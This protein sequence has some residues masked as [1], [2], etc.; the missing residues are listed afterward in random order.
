MEKT[1]FENRTLLD[2]SLFAEAMSAHYR[3][4]K[5]KYRIFLSIYSGISLILLIFCFIRGYYYLSALMFVNSLFLLFVFY[6]GYLFHTGKAYRSLAALNPG[7]QYDC[8]FFADH[9]ECMTPN[10]SRSIG[11]LQV[12][13]VVETENTLVLMI[14]DTFVVIGKHGFQEGEYSAVL[15]FLACACSRAKIH[16]LP[17]TGR[18]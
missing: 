13:D 6:K 16:R 1:R 5:K 12:S 4:S 3:I 18:R 11:Y 17:M 8:T 7:L 14:I 15:E 2:R 10:S 9:F